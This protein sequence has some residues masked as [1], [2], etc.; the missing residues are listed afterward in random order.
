MN[1]AI[2]LSLFVLAASLASPVQAALSSTVTYDYG[3]AST[4]VPTNSGSGAPNPDS[5]SIVKPDPAG[6]SDTFLFDGFATIT[7]ATISVTHNGNF[8]T[9]LPTG[10]GENWQILLN[11]SPVSG[12][13][14]GNSFY[15]WTTGT[16]ISGWKTDTFTLDDAAL[17]LLNNS[18]SL[19]AA[20]IG[21][22]DPTLGQNTFLLH[23]ISFSVTGEPTPVPLPATLVLFAPGLFM[24][25]LIC[26]RQG[27]G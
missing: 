4:H 19:Q 22:T 25:R 5:V 21:F 24:V 23:S 12:G 9:I 1:M 13:S 27:M 3:T 6:F 14:L 26:R 11:G 16:L 2:S 17:A 10:Y 7:Q 20:V 15:D 18:G 8:D